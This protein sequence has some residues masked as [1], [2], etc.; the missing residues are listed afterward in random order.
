MLI[1]ASYEGICVKFKTETNN[2]TVVFLLSSCLQVLKIFYDCPLN[3]IFD[4][5]VI[6]LLGYRIEFS[7]SYIPQEHYFIS[8]LWQ[9]S[10]N[11]YVLG[12]FERK[13]TFNVNNGALC[14]SLTTWS[15]QYH[16]AHAA[17]TS[18]HA[19]HSIIHQ[20]TQNNINKTILYCMGTL[21]RYSWINYI[22]QCITK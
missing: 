3:I 22:D 18:N 19:L 13:S 5:F 14:K 8:T 12:F 20:W 2:E 17:K 15:W 16:Q 4:D 6:W 11:E 10:T 9:R 21:T 7:C 1:N